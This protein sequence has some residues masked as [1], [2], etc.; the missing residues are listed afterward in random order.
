MCVA[1]GAKSSEEAVKK[2]SRFSR[3]R[4]LCYSVP[5]DR[6]GR[7]VFR[8]RPTRRAGRGGKVSSR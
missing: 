3:F 5:D 6:A 2:I 7:R 1:G 8:F 4:L